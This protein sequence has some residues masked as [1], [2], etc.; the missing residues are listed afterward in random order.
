[1]PLDRWTRQRAI[2]AIERRLHGAARGGLDEIGCDENNELS[3]IATVPRRFEQFAEHRHITEKRKL[4]DVLTAVALE[5]A[6]DGKGLSARELD[7]RVGSA[8]LQGR[9]LDT[10]DLDRS[11][12]R[13]AAHLRTDPHGDPLVRDQGGRK[14]QRHAERLVLDADHVLIDR[15]RYRNFAA[16][17][18]T[19]GLAS[20][21][22]DVGLGKD[23]YD[24]VLL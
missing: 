9:N 10:L 1:M 21:C 6:R 15:N 12:S 24:A 20:H 18:E 8:H 19:C 7:G 14:E 22:R 5:Q 17:K 3:L 4:V 16:G 13:Y 2:G 23:G 11:H